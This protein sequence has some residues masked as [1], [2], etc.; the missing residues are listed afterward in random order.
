[1]LV[2][3]TITIAAFVGDDGNN[4]IQ[5]VFRDCASFTDCIS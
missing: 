5:V 1:M 4:N 3:G 2:A